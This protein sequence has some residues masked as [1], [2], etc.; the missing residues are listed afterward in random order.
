MSIGLV[1]RACA[2]PRV[3]VMLIAVPKA[4]LG[5][6]GFMTADRATFRP[7]TGFTGNDRL[8]PAAG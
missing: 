3:L 1:T 2:L 5:G 7:R 6:T 4:E 8:L